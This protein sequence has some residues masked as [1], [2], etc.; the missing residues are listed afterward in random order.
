MN[1]EED[2]MNSEVDIMNSEDDVNS[3][4]ASQTKVYHS[5]FDRNYSTIRGDEME[6]SHN[7]KVKHYKT[8]SFEEVTTA[9]KEAVR[10]VI[11][12]EGRNAEAKDRFINRKLKFPAAEVVSLVLIIVILRFLRSLNQ[13]GNKWLDRPDIG[14]WLGR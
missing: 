4:E 5:D 7:R 8:E 13:T 3:E 1:S 10:N 14:D 12:Q 2:I 11:N 6:Y 9:G